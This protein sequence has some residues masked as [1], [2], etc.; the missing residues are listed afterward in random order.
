MKRSTLESMESSASSATR[1]NYAIAVS[2]RFRTH[3]LILRVLLLVALLL[4]G[5]CI[6]AGDSIFCVDQVVLLTVVEAG[7][8][9]AVANARITL[10]SAAEISEGEDIEQYLDRFA[11]QSGITGSDGRALPV[12]R[13]EG[14]CGGPLLFI[15]FSVIGFSD[16]DR[17]HE[18]DRVIGRSYFIQV[19]GDGGSEVLTLDMAEGAMQTGRIYTVRIEAIN[20]PALIDDAQ[21]I[22]CP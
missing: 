13:N 2:K 17:Q 15:G 8:D 11:P 6:G 20:E 5:G 7:T 12:A 22:G 14:G 4:F 16:C 21:T 10:A 18:R 3:L 1:L 19:S 9:Q